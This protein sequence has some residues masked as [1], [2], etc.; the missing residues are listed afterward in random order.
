VDIELLDH[1]L[2]ANNALVPFPEDGLTGI[3]PGDIVSKLVKVENTGDNPVW[4][5]VYLDKEITE[6]LNF[7]GITLNLNLV[8][9]TEGEDGW[10]YFN[11]ELSPEL[12][13][14]NLFTQ[15]IFDNSLGNEYVDAQIEI[16]VTAQAVQSQNNG[17]TVLEAEGWP[18]E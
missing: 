17:L 9:W 3:M 5:R 12:A 11:Q 4:V 10:F 16:E 8:D 13:T 18:A 15:V 2:N 14:S 1:T 7:E 6:G